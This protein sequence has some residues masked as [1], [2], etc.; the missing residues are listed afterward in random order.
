MY[1]SK[2]TRIHD[3]NVVPSRNRRHEVG[4]GLVITEI[5]AGPIPPGVK[6]VPVFV[7]SEGGE[8]CLTSISVVN[9]SN[10]TI[11]TSPI[12][13]SSIEARLTSFPS[14]INEAVTLSPMYHRFSG[15]GNHLR[16]PWRVQLQTDDRGPLS[17]S[18]HH[19][20]PECQQ[21]FR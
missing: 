15:Q 7:G 17:R 3:D 6:K 19:G 2:P 1:G 14:D 16:N 10:C 20:R 12:R 13:S 5:E 4:E 9:C 8:F 21:E 11:A 18:I